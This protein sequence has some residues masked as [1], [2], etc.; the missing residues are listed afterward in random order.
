MM[1][2]NVCLLEKFTVITLLDHELKFSIITK[3]L[4]KLSYQNNY[5]SLQ[6]NHLSLSNVIKYITACK[7]PP[8]MDFAD[9]DAGDYTVGSKRRYRCH[10]GFYATGPIIVQCLK[11]AQ[12][13][14]PEHS[15]TGI[16][17]LKFSH[18]FHLVIYNV[19]HRYDA[20]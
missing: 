2:G 3:H 7:E 6:T 13:S 15:C 10:K 14:K 5:L 8:L 17:L 4:C 9:V 18:P 12:W 19:Y 20:N 1:K 11:T 16:T